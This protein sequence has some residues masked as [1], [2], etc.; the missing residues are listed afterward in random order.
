MS[1]KTKRK[2]TIK[3]RLERIVPGRGRVSIRTRARTITE[4][5]ARIALFDRLLEAGQLET[6]G[7]LLSGD[8][9]WAELRQA[10]R[11]NRLHSDTL[12]ADIALARPLWQAVVAALPRM[13]NTESTR[14]RYE[15]AFAQIQERAADFLPAG[16]LVKDLQAAPWRDIFAVMHDL[17][18][19]SRNRVRSTVSAF[20]TVF[21]G[22]KWHPF[23]RA[24]MKAVGEWDDETAPPKEITVR[25][26]WKNIAATHEAVQPI[27]ITLAG[28]GLRV[29][30]FLQCDE[31]SARRLPQI[32]VAGGKTGSGERSIAPELLPFARQAI[33]CNIAAR[34]KLRHGK[35]PGVQFDARYKRIYKAMKDAAEATG[36]PWSPHYL[37][38][39]Y[40]QIGTE[41]L[42]DVLVQQGLGHA[43]SVM[44]ARY[45]KRRTTERVSAVVG[46]ALLAGQKGASKRAGRKSRRAS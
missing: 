5:K 3:Q 24:V 30:E 44:T 22:D 13:G 25:E 20:L 43:T 39:L 29:G 33:P 15:L 18:A 32:W 26:F 31:A 46:S 40:A 28:S 35:Y 37:R 36:I 21:L 16:A 2:R 34:P 42:P 23:R 11:K 10:Q 9:S 4:H 6:V 19:A 45:S 7:L 8:L 41:H 14:N 1:P 12:A 17:S 27:V 38:H